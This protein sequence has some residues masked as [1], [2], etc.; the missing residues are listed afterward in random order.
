[1][2]KATLAV[3]TSLPFLARFTSFLSP[4]ADYLTPRSTPISKN[5]PIIIN[6]WAFTDA[7]QSGWDVLDSQQGTALD[8]VQ[9]GASTCEME[10]CDGTVGFGGSPDEQ[11]ETTLD[12]MIMDGDTMKVGAVANLRH[13]KDAV[14]TARFVMEH[15]THTMLAGLQA[16][17]FALSMGLRIS[18]LTTEFSARLHAEWKEGHCQPNYRRDVHP[19]PRHH[20]GPYRIKHPRS[21]PEDPISQNNSNNPIKI[22]L[23]KIVYPEAG[24]SHDTISLVA[25]DSFGSMASA[26]ST[27]G[28]IFKVPGRVGDGAVAGGGSYVDSEVGGCGATGDGD[29]HLRFLPCFHVV[30]SMRQGKSPKEAAEE[31]MRRIAKRLKGEYFGAVVALNKDGEHGAA[32][33]GWQFRYS[34]RDGHSDQV[35]VIEVDPIDID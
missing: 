30:E 35:Q 17:Q 28:L 20:C 32:C 5:V 12:A 25:I 22:K 18:N 26:T 7:T 21:D 15:S 14:T 4:Q 1:M 2:L 8:A 24:Q 34:Y 33:Y 31:A 16:A 9:K 3:L 11:G 29:A 10:Q 19:N 13:V 6:T 27:N 23:D